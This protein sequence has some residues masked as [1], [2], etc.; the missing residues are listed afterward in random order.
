M[1]VII[2]EDHR[3]PLV[4]LSLRYDGGEVAAPP[5]LEAVAQLTTRLMVYATKHVAKDDYERLLARAGATE[6]SGRAS[7]NGITL[8]LT[9][10]ADRV[11]LPLWM[12]S[13]QIAYFADGLKDAAIAAKKSEL[14]EQQRLA[15]DGSPL[16]RLDEFADGEIYPQGHPYLHRIVHPESVDR[17]DRAAILAFHD[18]WMNP[19]HATLTLVGDI[20]VDKAMGLVQKYF[21]TLPRGSS[22]RVAPPQPV[23]LD[24]ETKVSV[25]AN[26]PQADVVIVWPTPRELS[27]ED[28]R[29]EVVAHCFKGD[30]T[31]WLF[32][33][34]VDDKRVA[35]GI[36]ARQ[37][38]GVWGSE[39]EVLVEGV[40]GRS[41]DEILT[42]FDE[43]MNE[44]QQRQPTQ[45]E[46]DSA[47]YEVTID[48]VFSYE[49]SLTRAS[50][51]GKF[52]KLAGTPDFAH[53]DFA[54][55][56]GI[57]PEVASETI[58]RWFPPSRRV[59][60]LV[61]PDPTAPAAGRV[62]SVA[63]GPSIPAKPAPTDQATP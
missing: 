27:I 28:A 59:V 13:D 11:A 25:D 15:I 43:A 42:A 32:W 63:R 21:G 10:P 16:S 29:L 12:W 41:A 62:K 57:T 49:R 17:V 37:R 22:E 39:F 14:R 52:W 1:T 60:L 20:T 51:Y 55:F 5:G 9:I 24:H 61:T 6:V 26:I 34:L 18:K 33:K 36:G 58:R 54:R 3:L 35:R 7:T 8:Q 19:A 31:A 23:R 45:W 4:S 56:A 53:R 47:S 38:A 2:E 48:R 40:P 46:L 30:R 44:I 50:E